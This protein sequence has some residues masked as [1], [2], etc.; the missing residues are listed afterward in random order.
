[1]KSMSRFF[2]IMPVECADARRLLKCVSQCL[3]TLG[4]TDLTEQ[5]LSDI[6]V[7]PVLVGGGTD[8]ASVN[9]SELNG[10]KG[11]VQSNNTWIMWSRCYAHCLEL[12]CKNA[13]SS[14]LFKS[15]EEMLLRLYYLYEKSS[16]KI[17]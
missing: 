7:G 5:K 14:L 9:I 8:G 11:L 4:V 2:A 13:F 16:Q 15:I 10:M 17:W 12:V 1:M 6:R 3:S